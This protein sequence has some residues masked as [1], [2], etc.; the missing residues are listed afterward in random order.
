MTGRLEGSEGKTPT[1]RASDLE[2]L[3]ERLLQTA[4]DR[5]IYLVLDLEGR[6]VRFNRYLEDLSGVRLDEVRGKDW[7]ETFVPEQDRARVRSLFLSVADQVVVVSNVNAIQTR[8]GSERVIDWSGCPLTDDGG[9]V[10]GVLSVGRDT[11]EAARAH[12]KLQAV[13]DTTIDGIVSIDDQG[14]IESFNRAAERMF[15]YDAEEVVGRNV[16]LLMPEPYRSEHDGYLARYLE[17]GQARI[18]GIGRDVVGQRKDGTQFPLELG[19]GERRTSGEHD[20]YTGILRDLSERE[21]LVSELRQAQKLEAVWRLSSGLAHEYK[22]LLMGIQGFTSMALDSLGD[23][24]ARSYMEEIREAAGRGSALA[25]QLLAYSRKEE[26]RVVLVCPDEKVAAVEPLLRSL[27]GEGIELEL[28]VNAPTA[29]V[30]AGESWF[31]QILLNLALNASDAMK[32]R[33]RL[34]IRT[35]TLPGGEIE[36]AVEDTGAG[37]DAETQARMFEPF[38]TTKPV[39]KGTGL[40]LSAVRGIVAEM[41]GRIEVDSQVGHGSTFRLQLPCSTNGQEVSDRLLSVSTVSAPAEPETVLVVEDERL[42]LLTTEHYLRKAGYRPLTASTPAD[43][44]ELARSHEGPLD[45]LLTDVSLP[46]M[47]GQELAQRIQKLHPS[48]RLLFMSAF[49]REKLTQE[50]WV[51]AD[52]ETIEKPFSEEQLRAR[53]SELAHNDL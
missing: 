28:E 44:L 45:I 7:F 22:N 41:N 52:A 5:A 17:T 18:I 23:S 31:E 26:P 25:A 3:A 39:G 36:L 40:G 38:F 43:A 19:V 32:G 9:R 16:R 1:P 11:S 48:V 27:L 47:G 8:D 35:R 12:A 29:R 46:V 10:C 53:L 34:G 33:G 15:G 24:P 4:N 20:G 6:I 50:G 21:Q 37:M 49:P 13:L 42:V 51:D 14:T 30:R 2:S